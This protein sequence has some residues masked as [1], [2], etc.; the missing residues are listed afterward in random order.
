MVASV[1]SRSSGITEDRFTTERNDCAVIALQH[2]LNISYKDAHNVLAGIGRKNRHGV[3]TSA[4]IKLLNDHSSFVR[5]TNEHRVK[6]YC[7][8]TGE[9]KLMIK[10]MTVGK[11]I[12]KNPNKTFIVN[13]RGH[14]FCVKNSTV[15]DWRVK[16]KEKVL[17]AWEVI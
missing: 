7:K 17:Y 16:P 14:T 2:A 3:V 8:Y 1:I 9:R 10:K 6:A 13:V 12:E 11:M 15:I 4:W 5:M